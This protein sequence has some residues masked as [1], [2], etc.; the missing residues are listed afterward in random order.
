MDQDELFRE[1][2]PENFMDLEYQKD[3]V[4]DAKMKLEEYGGVF[5]SDVVGLGKTFI[6]AMLA[7]QLDGRS[8]VIA[9]PVLLDKDNPG[10]WPNVFSDFG[11]RQTNFE[12]VGMLDKVLK[13][14]VEKYTNIFIDEAHRFRTEA[15]Q[16]YEKLFDICRGKRVI[17]VSATPLNNTPLDILSQIKLFQNAHKSTLP[18]PKVRDL[19]KYFKKLQNNL[20]GLNRQA[21][22]EEYLR[23]FLRNFYIMSFFL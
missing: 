9:P 16:M 11:V 5:V 14:G 7:Q 15:A 4:R 22:K 3:A 2:L 20:K 10:S 19:E 13:R 1:Y 17:L 12:S 8:L 18:N 21:D 23:I 6:S